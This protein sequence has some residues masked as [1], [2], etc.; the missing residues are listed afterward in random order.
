MFFV[1]IIFICF[2]KIT[3]AE[4]IN[5]FIADIKINSDSTVS[6]TEK[7]QYDFESESRH[8][9]FRTI[10][11]NNNDGSEISIDRI[12]VMDQAGSLYQ[13][14]K[15]IHN[16]SL[17]VKIGDP[18]KIVSGV[19]EYIISYTVKNALVSFDDY[20]ELYWNVTGNDWNIPIENITAKVSFDTIISDQ[21]KQYSCYKGSIRSTDTCEI[22]IINNTLESQNTNL[23]PNQGITIAV[24]VNKGIISGIAR[25]GG[26]INSDILHDSNNLNRIIFE[27]SIGFIILIISIVYR[28]NRKI[29]G[30]PKSKNPVIPWYEP[31]QNLSP[32][33]MG[34][35]I[36][37]KLDA[38]DITAQ[39]IFLAEKGYITIKRIEQTT[40]KIF[41]SVDYEF[42]LI[43]DVAGLSVLDLNVLDIIFGNNRSIGQIVHLSELKK[44][45]TELAVLIRNLID[46]GKKKL[47]YENYFEDT[48]SN[49]VALWSAFSIMLICI[50]V[51]IY[52]RVFGNEIRSFADT[53]I[54]VCLGISF[55]LVITSFMRPRYTQ[56]GRDTQQEIHGFVDFLS[57][58][59]RDRFDFHNAP[60]KSPT[61]FMEYLPYAIAF[62]IEKKWAE[63]FKDITIPNPVWYSG[64]V[65]NAFIASEFANSMK[66]LNSSFTSAVAPASSG[67][68]GGGFS[69]G[70]SGG[71]GGGGW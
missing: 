10:P 48:A 71:G 26:Q 56:F 54:Y 31:P 19:H 68:G 35:L 4:K 49:K 37:K 1:I 17:T 16:D 7:I 47:K 2:P 23:E 43:N 42:K 8:G 67:S 45:P 64:S 15:S 38:Q 62:G 22:S 34:L 44:N 55:I 11:L 65:S 46:E 53:I 21:I 32:I 39:I 12:S 33:L 28:Y 69:G 59:D 40:M 30:D 70:G 14:K 52:L 18:S 51:F 9:M 6:V 20:D 27:S 50:I 5:S 58:T 66:D 57:V 60:E 41:D 25:I 3:H 63:Q 13:F 61:Q 24:G 29:A 36:D